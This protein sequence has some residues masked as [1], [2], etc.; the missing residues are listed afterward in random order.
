MGHYRAIFLSP[1][2]DDAVFSCAGE[3]GRLTQDGSVCV[4]N[5]FTKYEA[6][7]SS[8][9][10]EFG[11]K[12]YEEEKRA[13]KILGYTSHNLDEYDAFFRDP[14]FRKIAN[15]FWPVRPID[16]DYLNSLSQRLAQH[17]S[18]L[19]FDALYVPLAVGWHV[20]HML[21]F[22][23]ALR[24]PYRDRIIFYEDAPYCLID[25]VTD[26]R[27]KQ[28]GLC[29]SGYN[30]LRR[31]ILPAFWNSGMMQT[32]KPAIARYAGY[33][34]VAVYLCNLLRAHFKQDDPCNIQLEENLSP[35]SSYA[36]I[37]FQAISSY[38]SQI[39]S[40]FVDAAELRRSYSQHSIRLGIADGM[41][42]R[43]WRLRP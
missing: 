7:T 2:L 37:K 14:Y 13:A 39:K 9:P 23:A 24:L 30:E 19:S 42:E 33:P 40:F 36:E 22:L 3:I 34:F 11:D 4:L 29:N 27:L 25:G 26:A 16:L 8:T 6:D 31:R 28:L 18:N 10:V 5:I 12:R 21:T 43:T 17:L 38:A 35:I 41:V 1:H 20:D 15:I 32:V